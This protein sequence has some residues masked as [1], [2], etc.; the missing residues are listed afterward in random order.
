M[1]YLQWKEFGNHNEVFIKRWGQRK[2]K[3]E[4]SSKATNL[5]LVGVTNLY[6]IPW[7]KQLNLFNH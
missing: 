5:K 7:Y 3:I 4:A 6:S 2:K 1:N